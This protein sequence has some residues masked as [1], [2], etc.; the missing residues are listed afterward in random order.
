[1][2]NSDED[3]DNFD[4]SDEDA[5]K[6]RFRQ[7]DRDKLPEPVRNLK[8]VSLRDCKSRITIYIDAD[9]VNHFKEAAKK[10]GVGYQTLIN[11]TLREV[12]DERSETVGTDELK[13]ELL[14]DQVFIERLKEALAA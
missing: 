13:E 10:E 2:R 1:M 6:K 9:I 8:N 14:H 4:F 12:V 7:I 5:F 11:Q 3:I